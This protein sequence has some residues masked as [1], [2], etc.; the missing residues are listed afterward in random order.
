MCL[1]L[2]LVVFGVIGPR[3][4]VEGL[5]LFEFGAGH[6]RCNRSKEIR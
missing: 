6:F 4:F 3:R 5:S 2:E 1:S